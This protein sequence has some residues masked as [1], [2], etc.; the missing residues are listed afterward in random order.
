MERNMAEYT[1]C[2]RKNKRYSIARW[3][4]EYGKY[5][6]VGEL[7]KGRCTLCFERRVETRNWMI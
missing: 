7:E 3:K 5:E 6:E 2:C 4:L 1:K